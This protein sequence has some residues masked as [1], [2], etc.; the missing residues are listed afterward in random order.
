MLNNCFSVGSFVA[1]AGVMT[2]WVGCSSSDTP[3]STA[4]TDAGTSS[5][6][7]S[8]SNG[9]DTVDSGSGTANGL[10]GGVTVTYDTCQTFA[11]CGGDVVGSWKVT[12]G[13]LDKSTF[14]TARRSCSQL[15]ESDVVIQAAGT[16]T[17]DATTATRN[18]TV[19]LTGKVFVP[20]ADAAGCSAANGQSCSFLGLGL[21]LGIAGS[22]LKFDSATCTDTTAP[23]KGCNCDVTKTT[24][25]DATQP[26]TKSTDGDRIDLTS[27]TQTYDYCING[28]TNTYLETTNNSTLKL[29][30]QIGK[31]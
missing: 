23:S 2:V 11:K 8:G 13:C 1:L 6:L 9:T 17:F 20:T 19:K 31:Q 26:Y 29:Y 7:D 18:T 22:A 25:D 15:Q 5:T 3:A 14:D 21:T 30:V 27:P 12:G 10:D 4:N 16:L 28:A 24:T